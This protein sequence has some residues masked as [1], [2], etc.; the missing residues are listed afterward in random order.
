MRRGGNINSSNLSP[1]GTLA[2]T[3]TSLTQN[4]T[5]NSQPDYVIVVLPL[6]EMYIIVYER[7]VPT[8][9]CNSWHVMLAMRGWYVGPPGLRGSL[10]VSINE[11]AVV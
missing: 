3:T 4:V 6:E 7:F 5:C 2:F 9:L 1:R 8:R 11:F 10:A